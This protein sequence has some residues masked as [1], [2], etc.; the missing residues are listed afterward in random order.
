VQPITGT[1]RA[2]ILASAARRQWAL[3]RSGFT[4]W[5]LELAK[6][7]PA[8]SALEERVGGSIAAA[9]VVWMLAVAAW[10]INGPFGDGHFA[11]TAATTVAGDNML[12]HGI[13]FPVLTY[14]D[15]LGAANS[16]MHHPLGDFW[17][18][19]LAIKVFGAHNWVARLPA[20]VYSTLTPFFVYRF[21]RA[22]WGPLEGALAAVAYVSLPITLGFSNFHALEGPVIAGIAVASWGYAR[23]TQTW[24]AP[25]AAASLL[26]F[27]WALN[28]DWP[29]YVWGALFLS[30]VFLRSF[31]LPA[32]LFG[33]VRPRAMGCY[34]GLMVGAALLSLAVFGKLLI[35]TGK[36]P[37]LLNM[38]KVRSTGNTIST[39]AV[40]RIRHVWIHMMFP[41]L[42]I[43]LGKLALPLIGARFAWRRNDLELFPI[44][45]LLMAA[46]QYVHFK[47]G[48]DVHIFWPQYF[49]LY[50]ALA[51]GALAAS[52]RDAASW[53]ARSGPARLQ[54]WFARRQRWLGAALVALPVLAVLKDGAWMIR[55]AQ[56]S[57]AR[58]VSTHIKS[59]IDRVD[60]IAWWLPRFPATEK[61]GFHTG[62]TPVHWSLGWE[63]RPH[64]LLRDQ[65]LGT[66]GASP[67]AYTLDSRFADATEL[68]EAARTFQV[69]AVGCFWFVDRSAPPGPLSGYSFAE[70]EPGLID[71]Y[72]R[73]GTEPVR[74]VRPDPW[75]TWEWR[76]LLGQPADAPN[77][78]PATPEQIR[79]AHNV[80]VA[81]DDQPTVARRRAELSR[82]FDVKR[83][84]RFD[85]GTEF[86][87]A[88]HGRGAERGMT[89]YFLTGPKGM[90]PNVKFSVSAK[91]TKAP[92][93]SSL[94]LDPEVI[95]VGLPPTVPS[96]LWKPGQ[97][98]SV[99]F[100]YRHRPGTEQL[101]GS[102]V[103]IRNGAAPAL[104]GGGRSVELAVL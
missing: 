44:F 11:A 93:L 78:E 54:G 7:F 89:L 41:G 97:I 13:L 18:A 87:G 40:L 2:Q 80:A 31:V 91:V 1:R 100:T 82:R 26:G 63:M 53:L 4:A 86:L 28:H 56:E 27:I 8:A 98:Y 66:H 75:V 45:I 79:V 37:E 81:N 16:Y 88:V 19:A 64:V 58:F 5:K 23:F 67:R 94:P 61:V 25:Y 90:A 29:G 17:V 73:G 50:F 69:D 85:D 15:A 77:A 104:V 57:G 83:T 52:L 32:R 60:A 72:L 84:A 92:R 71:W 3:A 76:T 68:R 47:Q 42:A 34:F 33:T 65:R 99:K 46:F 103:P 59:D 51:I 6:G 35:D 9:A 74:T 38:Y 48:A 95:E 20:V 12:R 102:F 96:A 36:L 30:W 49:A 43:L 39:D 101:F 22:T 10:G 24:R 14:V 21:G 62:I 55:L 70:R